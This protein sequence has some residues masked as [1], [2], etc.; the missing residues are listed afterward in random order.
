MHI[1]ICV[2]IYIHIHTYVHLYIHL[3]T[4]ILYT[5]ESIAKANKMFE[6]ISKTLTKTNG[7]YVCVT[8]AEH[9]IFRT[10]VTYFTCQETDWVIDVDVI[11]ESHVV[12]TSPFLPLCVAIQRRQQNDSDKIDGN[13][14]AT[15][16][17]IRVHFDVTTGIPLTGGDDGSIKMPLC[18]AIEKIP[19]VQAYAQ[20]SF[21]MGHLKAKRYEQY[22]LWDERNQTIPRFTIMI[23]DSNAASGKSNM[24]TLLFLYC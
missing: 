8:L 9:F 14:N 18:E 16:A 15:D 17:E 13:G 24:H 23:V 2:Y 1:Y 22:D 21:D 10:L 5:D 20:K 7:R 12:Q 11:R 6:C 19:T 4:F 3:H